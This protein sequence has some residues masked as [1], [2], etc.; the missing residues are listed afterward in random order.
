MIL[1][2]TKFITF[3]DQAAKEIR[4]LFRMEGFIMGGP[5]YSLAF[6]NPE[7]GRQYMVEGFV[8]APQFDKL[9]FLREIEAMVRSA[10]PITTQEAK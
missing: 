7:N 1:P 10:K 4:G 5:F 3:N 2:K 8:Y 6:F 9:K